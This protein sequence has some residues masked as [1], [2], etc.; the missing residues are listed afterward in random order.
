MNTQ[1]AI[2][3][4]Q[5]HVGLI[6]A[7]IGRSLT[8]ALHMREGEHC[9]LSYRYD[10]IDLDVRGLSVSALPDLVNEAQAQG[11]A[12]LNIT[13]PCKQS[14]V[15]LMDELSADAQTLRSINTVVFQRGR[16][17]GHNTDWWGFAESFRRGLAGVSLDHVVQ[18]GAG[19]AG[20]AVAHALAE[21][22]ARSIE[23]FDLDP[24][25]SKALV[26]QLQPA[27]GA[28]TFSVGR[29][30]ATA[31]DAADGL[32][33]AT[34]TG[35]AAHPGLPLNAQLLSDRLWVAEIVYFPIETELV[36]LAKKKGC[37]VL[38][39]GG[40]AVFQAVKAFEL[41]TGIRPTAER[42]MHHFDS[43]RS[44]I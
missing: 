10:L 36:T 29:D 40:M 1:A 5:L 21:M 7:G 14:A 6:G 24:L 13:H 41:F 43:L 16:R 4:R 11:F 26:D 15:A 38:D 2:I 23:I 42:M 37:R 27:H 9:G 30:L 17:I 33:H 12:G 18:L 44:M 8:P 3:P 32:V 20:V 39:G 35:M 31:L 25:R 22:G 19:G 28:C 34:P